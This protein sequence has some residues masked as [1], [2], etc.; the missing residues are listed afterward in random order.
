MICMFKTIHYCF[1][2]YLKTLCLEIYELNP[3]RFFYCTRISMVSSLKKTKVTEVDMLLRIEKDIKGGICHA[4]H[5]YV[6]PNNKFMKDLDKDKES[7]YL[8]YWDLNNMY[9]WAMSQKLPVNDFKC[10]EDISEI[11][12]SF[13]KNYNEKNDEEYFLGVGILCLQ[14]LHNLHN[15][16]I[17]VP[18]RMNNWK[19]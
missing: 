4:I 6:K 18:E 11:D 3:A 1:L 16:L 15:D 5:L 12:E 2:M 8:K 17:F 10:V 7:S 14:N 19:S 9:R 13:T